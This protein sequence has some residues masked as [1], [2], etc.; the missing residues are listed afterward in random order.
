MTTKSPTI[1]PDLL[2]VA[3]TMEDDVLAVRDF[4]QAL[5]LM[6]DAHNENP[7]WAAVTRV[8]YAIVDHANNI[9]TAQGTLFSGLNP[10]VR[11]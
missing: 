11:S 9:K 10:A 6:G 2:D 4:A 8:A 5:V 1:A 3:S 7:D